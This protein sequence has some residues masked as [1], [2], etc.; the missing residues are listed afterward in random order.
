MCLDYPFGYAVGCSAAKSC[1]SFRPHGLRHTRLPCPSP[2]PGVCLNSCPLSQW[3][4]PTVLSSVAPFS[5]CLQSFPAPGSF[6][7]SRLFASVAKV[8]ELVSASVH[9]VQHQYPIP[10]STVGSKILKGGSGLV[11]WKFCQVWDACMQ[12]GFLSWGYYGFR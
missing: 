4:H 3:Y 7:V 11:V 9:G 5:S 10:F 6:P 2:S 12:F 1:Q 8:L